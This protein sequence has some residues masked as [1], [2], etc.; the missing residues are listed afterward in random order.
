MLERPVINI[1]NSPESEYTKP[2]AWPPCGL[3]QIPQFKV[4]RKKEHHTNGRLLFLRMI[5]LTMKD[6]SILVV[7]AHPQH[8]RLLPYQGVIKPEIIV[9]GSP[10]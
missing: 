10:G 5:D 4:L 3:T 2:N 9:E 1:N 6:I 8:H 7:T